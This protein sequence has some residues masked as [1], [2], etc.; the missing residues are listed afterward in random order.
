M[1][2]ERKPLS[3][4]VKHF[5]CNVQKIED[6]DVLRYREDF[7][8]KLKKKCA[9]KEEFAEKLRGEMM[10]LFWSKCEWELII[11]LEED[12]HVI[13][14]PWCGARDPEEVAIDVT[15]DMT[16]DWKSFAEYHIKRQIFANEAKVDVWD[17]IFAKW[18]EFVTYIWEYRHKYQR[19]KKAEEK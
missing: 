4:N 2:N 14:L 19:T 18:D 15:N 17:Q 5:N 13:L 6:Y 11:R 3:W 16:F 9:T 10:Y 7:I 1:K 12:G 8:K